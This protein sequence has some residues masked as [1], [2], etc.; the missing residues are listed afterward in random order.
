[1][2]SEEG[3]KGLWPR[4][5]VS[6][7][8]FPPSPSSDQTGARHAAASGPRR[9][10]FLRLGR[11]FPGGPAWLPASP[12]PGVTRCPPS[13]W[14]RPRRPHSL[15]PGSP[16]VP[17][18]V[19]R[20]RDARHAGLAR[21]RP[22]VLASVTC[23]CSPARPRRVDV[24]PWVYGTSSCFPLVSSRGLPGPPHV[25]GIAARPAPHLGLTEHAPA[26]NFTS[27]TYFMMLSA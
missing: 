16:A 18:G 9:R 19:S 5:L 12:A 17:A 2:V 6:R 7:L 8:S 3:P 23:F 24:H 22:S 15:R 10:A 1:M 13:R 11:S 25:V 21:R 27:N 20:V 26:G 14:D 4:G